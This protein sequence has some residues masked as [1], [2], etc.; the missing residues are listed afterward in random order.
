MKETKKE[1]KV[2]ELVINDELVRLRPVN[3]FFVSRYRLAYRTGADMPLIVVDRKS[4]KIV[5]GNH[6]ATAMIKEFSAGHKIT[7]ICRSYKNKREIVEDFARENVGH[8]NALNGISRKR[9]INELLQE[10]ATAE[11]VAE[12]FNVPI[13]RIEEIG[14]EVVVVICGKNEQVVLP[15]KAGP[16]IDSTVTQAQYDEHIKVDRGV[17]FICEAQ[18]IIRWIKND[19]IEK[20]PDNF[21]VAQELQRAVGGFIE[22]FEKKAA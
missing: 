16:H 6:R 9:I 14:G 15:V 13:K 11:Q 1:I 12:L 2:S 22:S 10:G 21:K 19:W 20:N 3:G 7:V 8:G 5:S 18:Q 17:S 4:K